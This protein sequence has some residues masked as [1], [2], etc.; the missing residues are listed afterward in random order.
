MGWRVGQGQF[1][2]VDD[3]LRRKGLAE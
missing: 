3:W 2:T 1:P